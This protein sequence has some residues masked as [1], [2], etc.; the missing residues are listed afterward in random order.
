[1]VKSE[2]KINNFGSAKMI[3][4]YVCFW[5]LK[6]CCIFQAELQCQAGTGRGQERLQ[7]QESLY[8]IYV[9]ICKLMIIIIILFIFEKNL[10]PVPS[11]RFWSLWTEEF[12]QWTFF[13]L[14]IFYHH[15]QD[16]PP[17]LQPRLVHRGSHDPWALPQ[18]RPHLHIQGGFYIISY[19]CVSRSTGIQVIRL[20]RS[21]T[22]LQKRHFLWSLNLELALNAQ[23]GT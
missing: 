7:R 20:D 13:V 21:T 6:N 19:Y 14:L 11:L 2:P 3:N 22:K 1:M 10:L 16:R 17:V 9:F 8:S 4:T 15:L 12:K 23:G 5:F 18:T